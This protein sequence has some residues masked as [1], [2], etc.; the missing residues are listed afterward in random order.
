MISFY[1]SSFHRFPLIDSSIFL[2]YLLFIRQVSLRSFFFLFDFIWKTPLCYK[3][4]FVNRKRKKERKIRRLTIKLH[5]EQN[6]SLSFFASSFVNSIFVSL[7]WFDNDNQQQQQQHWQGDVFCHWQGEK[8][9]L[10]F[11][12]SRFDQWRKFFDFIFCSSIDRKCL[13]INFW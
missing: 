10:F 2:F 7:R 5:T 4:C 13:S 6:I 3:F 8:W 11:S 12:S 9:Y 1:P